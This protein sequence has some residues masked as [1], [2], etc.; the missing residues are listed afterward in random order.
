MT[1]SEIIDYCKQREIDLD[2]EI[3]ILKLEGSLHFEYDI[4]EIYLSGLDL[5]IKARSMIND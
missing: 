2:T 1:L 4:E 3:K 5:V